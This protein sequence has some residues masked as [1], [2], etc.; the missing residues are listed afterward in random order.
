MKLSKYLVAV[1]SWVVAFGLMG[2]VNSFAKPPGIPQEC[3]KVYQWH[4]IGHPG[5]Y[6]GGCGN[7]S[8]MFVDRNANHAHVLVVDDDDGWHIANCDATG[9]DWGEIH[10]DELGTY[11]VAVRIL[12][13]PG[14]ALDICADTFVDHQN[15]DHFCELGSINL[16]REGGKSQF[17]FQPDS[18]FDADLED[19]VWSVYTNDDFRIATFGV[20]D[21]NN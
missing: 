9:G 21:C 20:Y 12:G 10:T 8:R 13:K 6:D 7:G 2:G 1:F 19:L 15:G 4:M 18:I 17:G 3:D 11:D 16:N 14:G 5:D